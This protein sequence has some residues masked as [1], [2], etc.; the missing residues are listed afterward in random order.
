MAADGKL[1]NF[2]RQKNLHV[3]SASVHWAPE[4]INGAAVIYGQSF[5]YS[6]N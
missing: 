4:E 6:V 1:R 2:N 5:F 3:S